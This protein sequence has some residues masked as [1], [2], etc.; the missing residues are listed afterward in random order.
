[1][2]AAS[3]GS[4]AA[5][6]RL[7]APAGRST[8]GRHSAATV[9]G[10][11]GIAALGAVL[12]SVPGTPRQ[13]V[14]TSV[15]FWAIAGGM[16]SG[17]EVAAH[18]HAVAAE[19]RRHAVVAEQAQIAS[20]DVHTLD[21]MADASRRHESARILV[22][23]RQAMFDTAG[24]AQKVVLA[25]STLAT[26]TV[27]AFDDPQLPADL[28]PD[29]AGLD[30]ALA[31]VRDALAAQDA[32]TARAL[33]GDMEQRV[34]AAAQTHA[35]TAAERIVTDVAVVPDDQHAVVV[36]DMVARV[37]QAAAVIDV[38]GAAQ[39]AVSA[40]G[41]ATAVAQAASVERARV[42]SSAA[43]ARSGVDRGAWG[44][45]VNGKIPVSALSSP[46]FDPKVKLRD[47]AARALDRLN[48]AFRAKFGRDV[49]VGDSYRSLAAQFSTKEQRPTLA[50]APGTS[51]HGWGLAVDLTGG[52]DD[53]ASAQHRWMDA[54][55][56]EFGWVN[57]DW[58]KAE[59]FE[60]WH[61]EYVG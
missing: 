4:H 7:R 5:P 34:L 31:R 56:G 59:R 53:A 45:N 38:V 61:W 32:V 17:H 52:I 44:G 40:D 30:E 22:S 25:A 18:R 47:D 8:A 39:A 23:N 1:M 13:L 16:F 46:T 42:A 55:A 29:L 6:R 10:G 58:A 48:T 2:R 11:D 21:R 35:S 57:P 19:A 54:H 26:G 12:R 50:A 60:P 20:D 51:N 37:Q 49:V 43:T 3:R 24:R 41:A 33:V 14:V 9:A 27:D 28:P 36:G 15:V